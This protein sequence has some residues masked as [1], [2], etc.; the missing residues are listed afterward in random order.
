[1]KHRHKLRRLGA[2]LLALALCCAGLTAQAEDQPLQPA[3]N[4][5]SHHAGPSVRVLFRRGRDQPALDP[6]AYLQPR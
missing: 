1:M 5:A 4:R 2:V 3:G 6:G